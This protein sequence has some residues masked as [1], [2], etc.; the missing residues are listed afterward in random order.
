[1]TKVLPILALACTVGATSP[2]AQEGAQPGD[3][4]RIVIVVDNSQTPL[5]PLPQIRRGLQQFVNELPAHHELMLVTTGGQMNI[6][7]QPTRDYLEILEAAGEI[8][9]LRSSG[10]AL[11]GS[12]QEIYDRYLRTVERRYPM[13]VI[14][15]TDGP[16]FSQR[17]TDKSVNELLN[18]LT[19]TRVLVNAV[20]LT[21]TG[22]SFIRNV[23]LEMIKRTGGAYESATIA[24]ALPARLKVMAGRIAQQYQKVSPDKSPTDPRRQSNQYPK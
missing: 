21:S 23:T 8:N 11:I 9:F 18:G 6:R 13:F 7:V 2:A 20:M 16:D 5:E 19:R 15:S 24:T 4:M 22:T 12:V 1:M 3:P 14:I 10:N 17:I